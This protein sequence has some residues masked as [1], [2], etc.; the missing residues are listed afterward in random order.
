MLAILTFGTSGF[1]KHVN[2]GDHF[3]PGQKIPRMFVLQ[4]VVG[5]HILEYD[6]GKK[7]SLFWE[8]E[9]IHKMLK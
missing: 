5:G 7:H 8:A 6:T 1:Y 3:F 9:N 2:F 4:F